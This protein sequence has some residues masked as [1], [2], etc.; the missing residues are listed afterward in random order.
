MTHLE[1][2]RLIIRPWTLSEGDRAAFHRL[3]SDAQ[4][5]KFY[6]TRKTR[7]EADEIL[8]RHVANFPA[9]GLQWQVAC[10]K[11]TGEPIGFTGLA[12]VHDELPFIPCVEIGWLYMPEQWGKGYATEAGK[13]LLQQGFEHHSLKEIVA[14]A[15]HN[16]HPS[17]AVMERIGMKR[18]EGGDFDH[19]VIPKEMAHLNPHVLYK[20][21]GDDQN[22][23]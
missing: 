10:V 22:V 5:R 8:E 18:V 6:V 2:D 13:A 14:F 4:I 11:E 21:K 19:P 9:D 7:E 3:M 17:I 23:T 16:N 1:T 12:P 20:V 15:V